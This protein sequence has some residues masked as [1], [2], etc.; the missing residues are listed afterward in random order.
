MLLAVL[1]NRGNGTV[2]GHLRK[3]FV[4]CVITSIYFIKFQTEIQFD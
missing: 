3:V 2:I 4:L 1:E